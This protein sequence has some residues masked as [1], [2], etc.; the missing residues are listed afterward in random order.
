MRVLFKRLV[1]HSKSHSTSKTPIPN[2]FH[3]RSPSNQSNLAD[4]SNSG[5]STEAIALCGM[6]PGTIQSPKYEAKAAR[7]VES[8]HKAQNSGRF[9]KVYL[10]KELPPIKPY[11]PPWEG[12][13]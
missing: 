8:G 6:E 1:G 3:G 11:C 7:K 13:S 5:A 12:G 4:T 9:S 2:P 10:D